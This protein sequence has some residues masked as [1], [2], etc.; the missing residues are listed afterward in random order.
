MTAAIFWL[1]V[2]AGRRDRP[3]V[4]VDVNVGQDPMTTLQIE[5]ERE[6]QRKLIRLMTR[7]EKEEYLELMERLAERQR[8]QRRG[9]AI[10]VE[11]TPMPEDAEKGSE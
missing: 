11:A 1:K 9:E 4:Q 2:Y 3:A 8:Q 10:E 5:A 7:D 6:E